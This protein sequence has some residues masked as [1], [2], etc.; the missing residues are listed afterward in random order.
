MN[1]EAF[2]HIESWEWIQTPAIKT[3]ILASDPTEKEML[4][5]VLSINL[6]CKYQGLGRRT[7]SI[8]FI[9]HNHSPNGRGKPS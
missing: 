5:L 2:I 4:E 6:T 9:V 3:K 7:I 8:H 1:M